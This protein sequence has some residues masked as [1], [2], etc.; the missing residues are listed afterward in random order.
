MKPVSKVMPWPHVAELLE[1][2]AAYKLKPN[3]L[4]A[5]A[6]KVRQY[7]EVPIDGIIRIANERRK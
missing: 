5:A 6:H 3:A 1:E 2:S 7:P 4:A